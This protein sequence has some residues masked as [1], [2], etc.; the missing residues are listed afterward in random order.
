MIYFKAEALVTL[1][2]TTDYSYPGGYYTVD[3]QNINLICA[4]DVTRQ[5]VRWSAGGS[6][7]YTYNNGDMFASS[8]S[9]KSRIRDY[10]YTEREHQLVFTVNKNE[11]D[12][13]HF[14]CAVPIDLVTDGED[15]IQIQ[16]ILGK[17]DI[18][19]H[20]IVHF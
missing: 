18:L 11:D 2:Y 13:Q 20:I 1:S 5:K 3:G 6:P 8:S 15:D 7:I 10:Q 19:T 14:K 12:G 9:Y 17:L 16:E 4:F